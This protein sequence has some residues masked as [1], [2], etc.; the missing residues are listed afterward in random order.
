[1]HI[2]SVCVFC[3]A[4][5]GR[6]NEYQLAAQQLGTFLA[7]NK[8]KLV[9]GGGRLGLMGT[10][11]KAVLENGGHV[12]G[13]IPSFFSEEVRHEAV[14]E[15]HVV[16]SMH[17]R[18]AKMYEMSDCFIALPGGFGTLEELTEALT[19]TQL[20]LHNK[21]CGLLNTADYYG[22]LLEFF[23]SAIAEDI[24][25]GPLSTLLTVATTPEELLRQMD[26]QVAKPADRTTKAAFLKK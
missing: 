1:M 5:N 26:E 10:V 8:I 19:W 12:V 20:G 2:K 21:P 18:K 17:E 7:A 16:E 24:I 4:Y 13:I 9:Y 23:E 3:G 6:R 11:S 15:L 25:H 14:T 22:H